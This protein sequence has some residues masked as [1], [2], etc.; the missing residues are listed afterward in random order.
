M[1]II[2]LFF[3]LLFWL[4]VFWYGAVALE[5]AGIERGKA[6]FQALSALSGTGF[7]TQESE[8]VVIQ[9]KCRRIA[10]WLI[11]LGRLG[12]A[13]LILLAAV[14]AGTGFSTPAWHSVSMAASALVIFLSLRAGLGEYITSKAINVFRVREESPYS[15]AGG[16][17]HEKNECGVA[18]VWLSSRAKAINMTLR[19]T[20]FDTYGIT[21]LAI[22]RR[23]K[24]IKFPD[25]SEFLQPGDYILCYG[26]LSEITRAAGKKEY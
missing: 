5:I 6:R 2:V 20:G 25:S 17:L 13:G 15:L 9:P 12:I 3:Y 8:L 11:V 22:E 14:Y 4:V 1:S 16:I 26:N 10:T 18:R 23:D 19:D 7:T 24:V 21:V